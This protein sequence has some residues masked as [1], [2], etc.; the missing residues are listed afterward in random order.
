MSTKLTSM[1]T[2]QLFSVFAGVLSELRS[3]GIV[4]S[5]NNPIADYSELLCEKALS[6]QRAPKSTK[7]FDA[8]DHAK[9]KYEIKGRRLTEHNQ[10]RQLSALR[11]L[12][13]KH[14]T[15]L[16]GVLFQEDYSVMR[17]CLV[18]HKQVLAHSIYREH[19]NAWIF[20][21]NDTVWQ[22]PGVIDITSKLKRA[23]R[24]LQR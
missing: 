3:R 5:T 15:F 12:D 20:N 1:S 22:L 11:A 8:V 2:R 6:L 17:G 18:P 10:S 23:E 21:L 14:F 4:R 9:R 19:T 16:A 24:E 7:G 13:E